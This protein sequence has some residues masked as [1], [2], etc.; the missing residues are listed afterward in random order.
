MRYH[1]IWNLTLLLFAILETG[2]AAFV[3]ST[4]LLSFDVEGMKEITSP[5]FCQFQDPGDGTGESV[6]GL[7]FWDAFQSE[8]IICFT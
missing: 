5:I 6:D 7:I 1:A 2:C 8:L 3:L 4:P